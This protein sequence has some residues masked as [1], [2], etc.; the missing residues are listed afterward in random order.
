MRLLQDKLGNVERELE[1]VRAEL[2]EERTAAAR[3]GKDVAGR[4]KEADAA[5]AR[6]RSLHRE[7]LKK[8][9]RDKQQLTERVQ[10]SL[11]VIEHHL[12]ASLSASHT[13]G[14]MSAMQFGL[15]RRT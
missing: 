13:K 1:W 8:L 4:A 12:H 7:E 15:L 9:Q 6:L 2:G 10:V 3:K 11:C 5:L 14:G